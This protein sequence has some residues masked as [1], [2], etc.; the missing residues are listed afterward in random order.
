MNEAKKYP[1]GLRTQA[2]QLVLDEKGEDESLNAVCRR[3]GERLS[4]NPSTL[5]TWVRQNAISSQTESASS[6]TSPV[7]PAG[8][9]GDLSS[10]HPAPSTPKPT[11]W[12]TISR[13]VGIGAIAAVLTGVTQAVGVAHLPWPALLALGT[14]LGAIGAVITH[15]V[16]AQSIDVKL[17]WWRAAVPIVLLLPLGTV[18]YHEW[19]DPSTHVP[20]SYELVVNGNETNIIPLIGEPGGQ[21]QLIATGS[22]GQNGLVG[23]QTYGFDCW[24][25]TSDRS[26]WV[27]YH[28]FDHLWWAPRSELHVPVGYPAPEIPP[29]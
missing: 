15:A 9:A 21:P 26:Q 28:R 27:Q 23:G 25:E 14:E 12:K 8:P 1:D 24:V 13:D 5:R 20:R 6:V 3:I 22:L 4:V 18:A 29:C 10:E 17:A 11:R 19:F 16:Q 7:T 2:V